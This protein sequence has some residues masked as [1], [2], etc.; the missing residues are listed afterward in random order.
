M[1]GPRLETERLLLRLLQPGDAEAIARYA[2]DRRV[3]AQT[4]TIPHPYSLDMAREFIAHSQRGA[5]EGSDFVF[6]LLRK[7]ERELVGVIGLRPQAG[8]SAEVGYWTGAPFWGRG[9]M[10]EALRAVIDHIFRDLGLRRVHASHFAGNPASGRVMQKAGMQY[11]ARL[12]QHVVRWGEAHDLV[13]YGLLRDEYLA[14]G[15]GR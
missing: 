15:G 7:P 4:L 12:R 9:Y 3:A 10:T 8:H 5:V 13:V 2:G 11:E 1:S 14:A 6:A